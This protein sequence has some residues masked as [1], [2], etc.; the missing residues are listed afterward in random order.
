[1]TL[2]L[3]LAPKGFKPKKDKEEKEAIKAVKSYQHKV[4]A[5]KQKFA[6]RSFKDK[7]KPESIGMLVVYCKNT[8]RSNVFKTTHRFKC[9]ESDI[10]DI[11]R[12]IADITKKYYNGKAI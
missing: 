5:D 3:V 7:K 9:V 1:M 11:T 12:G 6:G 10:S 4:W 8:L 2:T